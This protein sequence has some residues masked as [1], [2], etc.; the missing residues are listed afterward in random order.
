V[1]A[2]ICDIMVVAVLRCIGFSDEKRRQK[3]K[4]GVTLYFGGDRRVDAAAVSA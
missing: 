1:R 4:G 2:Y 3:K